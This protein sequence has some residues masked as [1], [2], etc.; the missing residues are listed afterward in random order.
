MCLEF[1]RSKTSEELGD[2]E[3]KLELDKRLVY[4]LSSTCRVIVETLRANRKRG[5]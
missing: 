2:R 5:K 1:R 3:A 4:P